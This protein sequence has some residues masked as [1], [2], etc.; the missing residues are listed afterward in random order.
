[1]IRKPKKNFRVKLKSSVNLE[2]VN[3]LIEVRWDFLR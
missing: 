2:F 3:M 1:L